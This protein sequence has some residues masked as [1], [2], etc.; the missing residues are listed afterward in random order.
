MENKNSII[1]ELVATKDNLRNF[2]EM[3]HQVFGKTS[4]ENDENIQ[5]TLKQIKSNFDEK[6]ELL[7]REL[8]KIQTTLVEYQNNFSTKES[9]EQEI[10]DIEKNNSSLQ[11]QITEN[12]SLLG[13]KDAQLED[14]DNRI[15][16]IN[17]E[18]AE[19]RANDIKQK[20]QLAQIIKS[21]QEQKIEL[22][23]NNELLSMER[24][25][26]EN[27]LK[28]QDNISSVLTSEND[29]LK[30]RINELEEQ[31]KNWEKDTTSR[32]DKFQKINEQLQKMNVESIQLKAHELELEEDNRKLKNT[33]EIDKLN[34]DE[35]LQD[36]SHL[37][38]QMIEITS[39]KHQLI[40]S[41][42]NLKE[43]IESFEENI[44]IMRQKINKLED[45]L[46]VEM[47][48]KT[49]LNTMLNQ[50]KNDKLIDSNQLIMSRAL[51]KNEKKI[52]PKV[53]KVS[54]N[55]EKSQPTKTI[56]NAD[57]STDKKINKNIASMTK[58]TKIFN[59]LSQQPLTL[60][61]KMVNK[62]KCGDIISVGKSD[63]EDKVDKVD[64]V[65][66][67]EFDLSSSSNDDFEFTNPSPIAIN[68]SKNRSKS[69]IRTSNITRKKLILVD[70]EDGNV[71]NSNKGY[72]DNGKKDKG[73]FSDMRKRRRK[74]K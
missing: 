64:N 14:K 57:N 68:P 42:L 22:V 36:Y 54:K 30:Q 58:L 27:K 23:K 72:Y 65:V 66:N 6:D 2:F 5:I 74:L 12:M 21:N 25:N 48:E 34:Y 41:N 8:S 11:Q 3:N 59:D 16:E 31:R 47:N 10:K 7:T 52:I 9:Y 53:N 26:F 39:E 70:E 18:I 38:Q 37:K 69:N 45:E 60:K 51:E 28:S 63:G 24:A 43:R 67:D 29:I 19:L 61:P 55:K 33:L 46:E 50:M 32:L 71:K 44:K 35:N 73:T 20:D 56:N 4:L 62:D 15:D 40:S 49:E 17:I 1:T 13:T